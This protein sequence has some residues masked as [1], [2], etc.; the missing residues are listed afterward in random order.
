ME[1]FVARLVLDSSSLSQTATG[2]IIL[3]CL[4]CLFR[5][6]KQNYIGTEYGAL[7]AQRKAYE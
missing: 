6:G 1:S 7:C 5:P 4:A 2:R 3:A